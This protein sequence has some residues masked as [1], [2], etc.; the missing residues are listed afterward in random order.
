MKN[1]DPISKGRCGILIGTTFSWTTRLEREQH[2]DLVL[3]WAVDGKII[4][5]TVL[6]YLE[7]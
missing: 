4:L 7:G 1:T 6:N 3:H 2:E 5:V